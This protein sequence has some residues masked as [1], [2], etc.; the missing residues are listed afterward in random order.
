[1]NE[2]LNLLEQRNVAYQLIHHPAVYTAEEADRYVTDYDFARAKNLFLQNSHGFFLVMVN[3]DQRLD[4]RLLRKQLATTRLS[5]AKPPALETQLGIHPGAVSP[6]S[7]I[8]DRHHQVTF[9]I[10]QQLLDT[11]Q[12]IGCHPNDNTQTVILSFT[13]LIKIIRQWGNPIKIV[14]LAKE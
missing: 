14:N 4:M 7:L 13:D 11:N 1:M 8:N 2:I 5:F 3:D 9:V 12:L 6:F 10:S